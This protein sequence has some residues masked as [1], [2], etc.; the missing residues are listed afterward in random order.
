M[1]AK[2][3]SVFKSAIFRPVDGGQLFTAYSAELAGPANYVTKQD[4]RRDLDVEVRREGHEHFQPTTY[5]AAFPCGCD[6]EITLVH[7]ARRPNG[8]VALIVGTANRLFRFRGSDDMTY[9]DSGYLAASDYFTVSQTNW[10][11]IGSGFSSA[12]KRWQAVNLNGYAVFNNGVDLP[13]TY[14]VEDSATIPIY[15]LREAGIASVGCI[16]SYNGILLLGDITEIVSLDNWK[17]TSTPYG[18][19]TAPTARNHARLIWSQ[20]TNPKKFAASN[21]GSTTVSSTLLVMESVVKSY[22]TGDQITVIGAGLDGGNLT[23]T[24]ASISGTTVFMADEASTAVT[25]AIVSQTAEASSIIGYEDIE[26]DGSGI[27]NMAPLQNSLIIYKDTSIFVAEYTG[28]ITAPFKFRLIKVPDSKTLYYKN[29]LIAV[30]ESMHIYAGRD[31]F[32][33]FDLSARGPRE[34]TSGQA[35]KDLLYGVADITKTDDVFAADNSLTNEIWFGLPAHDG[36]DKVICFDYILNTVSTTSTDIAS[37]A[38]IK[39]PPSD[40]QNWFIMGT[41][42]GVLLRYGLTNENQGVDEDGFWGGKKAIYYR[43]NANPYSLAKVQYTS[44]IKSGLT[45]F[46]D[47]YN[48]KDMRAYVVQLASQQENEQENGE[49]GPTL[50]VKLYGYENPYDESTT[51]TGATPYQITK[52]KGQNLIPVFFRQHLFQ[53]EIT[54][55]GTTN[56]RLA[57]RIFDVSKIKSS[58]EVR[59]PAIT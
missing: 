20:I 2:A 17:A 22:N 41:R 37:A 40:D 16:A 11:T 35:V 23:T 6:E 13:V 5:A 54:V 56:V 15:E 7:M 28:S 50:D 10:I 18:I 1:A 3:K 57:G 25:S 58:S 44:T 45:D 24:M 33:A 19:V 8:E 47:S 31:N 26:D 39:K 59:T 9:V 32:Y 46:G 29:T 38:T 42:N 52:P 14:R 12:G 21:K 34:L 55:T 36:N 53:D 48:E 4:W 27:I 30:K 49:D 51:L 43:M